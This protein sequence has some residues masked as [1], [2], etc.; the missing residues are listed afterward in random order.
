MTQR[1]WVEPTESTIKPPAPPP[2]FLFRVIFRRHDT[3]VRVTANGLLRRLPQQKER[4]A[5]TRSVWDKRRVGDE[6]KEGGSDAKISRRE[7][8]EGSCESDTL[9]LSVWD[10]GASITFYPGS[11]A[12]A[13]NKVPP[14]RRLA[15]P[16]FCEGC[17]TRRPNFFFFLHEIL[18]QKSISKNGLFSSIFQRLSR[19][20][21]VFRQSELSIRT[22]VHRASNFDLP[23]QD[24]P[25]F[26]K[27][28]RVPPQHTFWWVLASTRVSRKEEEARL[29]IKLLPNSVIIRL[30]REVGSYPPNKGGFR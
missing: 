29:T 13:R 7:R 23:P 16:L 25:Y 14:P 9:S 28:L 8:G 6:K 19:V 24:W 3:E 20:K 15:A 17:A 11:I 1:G 5:K 27:T 12:N 26:T 4:G 2:R 18:I 22:S 21:G 30:G 10:R